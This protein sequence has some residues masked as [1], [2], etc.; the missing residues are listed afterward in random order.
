VI[1]KTYERKPIARL[2]QALRLLFWGTA[3]AL[4]ILLFHSLL[5]AAWDLVWEQ[6]NSLDR[7]LYFWSYI[8]VLV[9]CAIALTSILF[10][11]K[12]WSSLRLGLLP[13][14]SGLWIMAVCLA[15][16][17]L[18]FRHP[19]FAIAAL[20]VAALLS[21]SLATVLRQRR[22]LAQETTASSILIDQYPKMASICSTEVPS[23]TS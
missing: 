7:P 16:L 4:L 11:K 19:F 22:R 10:L 23:S 2:T 18:D 1:K 3:A 17:L 21:Y 14:T 13:L 5:R 12:L 6:H 9:A 20:G 8:L 15:I